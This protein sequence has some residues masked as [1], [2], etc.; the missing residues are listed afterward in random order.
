MKKKKAKKFHNLRFFW[1]FFF[2]FIFLVYIHNLSKD[3]FGGDVGDLVTSA[4]TQGIAHPPGYPLFMILGAFFALLPL[5]IL[6]VEKIGLISVFS[7]LLAL[8]FFQKTVGL[9]VKNIYF[10]AVSVGTLAFSYLFFL[11]AE[12]PEVFALN[13]FLSVAVIYFILKF[14][15]AGEF[16]NLL[17]V[18][19]FFGL[20]M[21]NHMTIILTAPLLI[22]ILF[23]KRKDILK[24]KKRILLLPLAFILGLLPYLYLPLASIGNPVIEWNKIDSLSSFFHHVLRRDYGTFSAGAFSQP[25]AEAKVVILRTYLESFIRSISLPAFLISAIGVGRVF[26]KDKKLFAGLFL[27][28]LFSGPFF[29]V[30]SGFPIADFFVMGIAERFYLLSQVIFLLFLPWG[31]EALYIF[32]KNILS[33]KIYAQIIMGI[34]IL[35]PLLLLKTN[36]PKTDFSKTQLGTT[37]AKDHFRNLEKNSL[38]FLTGDTRSFNSWYT[39]YVLGFRND[40]DIA[41]IGGFGIKSKYFSPLMEELNMQTGFEGNE[42]FLNAM[43]E[44]HKA[45]NVYSMI[46]IPV[47]GKEYKWLQLGLVKK[48][49]DADEIPTRNEYAKLVE[50]NLENVAIPYEENLMP[51]E[52]S[53]IL[54]NI[55]TYYASA[56]SNIGITYLAEYK[57]KKAAS[58]YFSLA[59]LIDST[60]S[61]S[62]KN[63]AILNVLDKRCGEAEK[64]IKRAISLYPIETKYYLT[65]YQIGR[66]CYKNDAKMREAE[67]EFNERFGASLQ[68]AI[69]KENEKE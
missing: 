24:F 28:F 7:S 21:S 67:K 39:Y 8:I 20:G 64:N 34:F 26:A 60:Y 32:F 57:D 5:P 43:L 63:L 35:I 23:V 38:L 54:R 31:F 44:A 18:F 2:L 19:L 40:I 53:L 50:K 65:W 9:M 62:Y 33:K 17:F 14:Y 45:K 16:K 68:D 3:I 59:I 6:A 1:P 22:T 52:R 25:L 61:E 47:P 48:L 4:I 30:Y 42:L 55:L 27:S 56:M 15:K 13:A 12:I 69:N 29:I 58:L 37:F 66:E 51:S 46:E 41:Q 10:Q 36:L 11:Y 49:F